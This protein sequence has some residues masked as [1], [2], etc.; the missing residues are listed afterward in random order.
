MSAHSHECRRNKPVRLVVAFSVN[1]RLSAWIQVVTKA[2]DSP[3]WPAV[4]FKHIEHLIHFRRVDAML[5]AIEGRSFQYP[6]RFQD[7]H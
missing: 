1:A 2:G 3:L 7:S 6:E 4:G 5:S